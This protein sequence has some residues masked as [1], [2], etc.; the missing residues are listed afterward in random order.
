M[1]SPLASNLKL[2]RAR[3][4]SL[5][6]RDQKA[7][8]IAVVFSAALVLYFGM[9]V[10]ANEFLA[11]KRADRDRQLTLV[12]Y[13]RSTEKEARALGGKRAGAP[14][15]QLISHVSRTAQEYGIP[16]N[17]LQPEGSDSV[18]VWFDNVAFDD[19]VR[20]LESQSKQGVLVRQVSIDR[21]DQPG[22]VNA[23]IVLRS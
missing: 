2:L 20:W 5:E 14:G 8:V 1:T 4:D 11:E 15:G 6:A 13:M 7:L 19:L 9:W 17:R 3:Y 21:Q 22:K 16:P 18:S 12:Q 23:R 10:P